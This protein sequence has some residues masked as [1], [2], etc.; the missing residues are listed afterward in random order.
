MDTMRTSVVKHSAASGGFLSGKKT[1]L[2]V[3]TPVLGMV[4][5]PAVFASGKEASESRIVRIYAKICNFYVFLRKPCVRHSAASG[6]FFLP[7]KQGVYKTIMR[8]Y[9]K[10]INSICFCKKTDKN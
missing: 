7:G 2:G 1:S 8:I 3:K 6:V 4:R 9:E 10:I 5:P